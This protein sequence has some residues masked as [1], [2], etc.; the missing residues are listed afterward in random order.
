VAPPGRNEP[1]SCG[2]GKKYKHCCEHKT[3]ALPPA[4]RLLIIAL[5]LAVAV[6]ILVSVFDNHGSETAGPGRVW[7]P[8][9]GH[10]HDR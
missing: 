3:R 8:E 4:L 10:Y 5:A 7:S 6:A 1:C 2:S 9:H